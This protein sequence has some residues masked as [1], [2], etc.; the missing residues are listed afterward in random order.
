[1][2][3]L[4]T[5]QDAILNITSSSDLENLRT[6]LS[7]EVFLH[8]SGNPYEVSYELTTGENLSELTGRIHLIPN[9]M[10]TSSFW[11]LSCSQ[12]PDVENSEIG[13]FEYFK[14]INDEDLGHEPTTFQITV[15]LPLDQFEQLVDCAK[16]N[17]IPASIRITL[18][19]G[20]LAMNYRDVSALWDVTE[21][22]CIAVEYIHFNV[23]LHKVSN[24]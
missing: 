1:M 14:A 16:L 22:P 13:I 21:K 3:F 20:V 23:P 24:T 18:K 17:K 5:P 12:C 19:S 8:R 2:Q 10:A 11:K 9:E 6:S 15:Q 4:F 7:Y